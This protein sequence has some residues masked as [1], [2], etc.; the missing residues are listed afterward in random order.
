MSWLV[1]V[2][3]PGCQKA[4]LPNS[5]GGEVGRAGSSRS[6]SG[7]PRPARRRSFGSGEAISSSE[8]ASTS[9]V[10]GG[11]PRDLGGNTASEVVRQASDDDRAGGNVPG[12]LATHGQHGA[13]LAAPGRQVRP[14]SLWAELPCPLKASHGL[15]RRPRTRA[16]PA[17]PG[18]I[19]GDYALKLRT[20]SC[21]APAHLS[22]ARGRSR[23]S[24]RSS[25]AVP[26]RP[27]NDT[28]PPRP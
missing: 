24:S 20:A 22:Q 2:L 23:S 11:V 8:P 4:A 26:G 7:D 15:G 10:A 14:G 5:D 17:T 16:R 13:V 25:F 3:I 28:V 18:T 19:S 9:V 6:L 1:L 21:M 12:R 27:V